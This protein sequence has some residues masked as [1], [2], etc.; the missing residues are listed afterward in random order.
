MCLASSPGEGGRRRISNFTTRIETSADLGLEVG[1]LFDLVREFT[2]CLC[3]FAVTL[4]E[5]ECGVYR[6]ERGTDFD[7]LDWF[8]DAPLFGVSKAGHQIRASAKRGDQIAIQQAARFGRFAKTS[9]HDAFIG[10]E[11]GLA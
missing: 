9:P 4:E 3:L 5:A 8:Q 1:T 11:D 2:Q 6:F 10:S 7:Q